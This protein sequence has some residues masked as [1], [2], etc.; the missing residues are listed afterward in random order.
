MELEVLALF[1]L[2]QFHL[3]FALWSTHPEVLLLGDLNTFQDGSSDFSK[4]LNEV[5]LNRFDSILLGPGLGIAEETY[6]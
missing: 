5:E 6:S 1:C 4:I 2:I 3:L